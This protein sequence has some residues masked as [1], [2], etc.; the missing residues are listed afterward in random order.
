MGFI[1]PLWVLQA[2]RRVDPASLARSRAV[3]EA[4]SPVRAPSTMAD[5]APAAKR[6]KKSTPWLLE[7]QKLQH[8][9]LPPPRTAPSA[10]RFA[11]RAWLS[12]SVKRGGGVCA[13]P[14]LRL[15]AARQSKL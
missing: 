6:L 14:P 7:A 12:E 4:Q 10:S 3:R 15:T 1:R 2:Q 8:L 11:T 13:W 5:G 9:E